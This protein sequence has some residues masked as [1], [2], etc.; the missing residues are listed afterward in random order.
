MKKFFK[1][2]IITIL[3]LTLLLATSC[4]FMPQQIF[5]IDPIQNE[6]QI[7][8]RIPAEDEVKKSEPS[9]VQ[10]NLDYRE[11]YLNISYI[12]HIPNKTDKIN[13]VTTLPASYSQRQKVLDIQYFPQPSREFTM[14]NNQYAEFVIEKPQR[15]FV[16][17]IINHLILYDYDLEAAIQNPAGNHQLVSDKYLMPE[18]YLQVDDAEIANNPVVKAV[19]KDPLRKIRMLYQYILD[20]LSYESYNSDSLGAVQALKKGSGDCTEYAD[21]LIALYRCSGFPAR[22]VEGYYLHAPDLYHGHDWIEVYLDNYGWIPLDAAI[23]DGNGNSNDT[24]FSNLQ[25]AYVYLSFERNDPVLNYYHFYYYRYWGQDIE[26]T[27]SVSYRPT[28]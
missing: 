1:I 24:T 25:N 28:S 5:N 26:V 13:L 16:I 20:N 4:C 21:A 22:F 11:I 15:D 7:R 9:Q 17:T 18:K 14:E 2:K 23:D 8:V 12:L 3:F 6:S 19:E 27:K 10:K